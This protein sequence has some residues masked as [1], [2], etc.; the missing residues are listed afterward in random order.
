MRHQNHL[1]YVICC[2]LSQSAFSSTLHCACERNPLPLFEGALAHAV[3]RAR[4]LRVAGG[5]QGDAR[6]VG[7]LHAHPSVT[8]GMRGLAKAFDPAGAA[9]DSLVARRQASKIAN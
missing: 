3:V 6:V 2:G 5:T 7:C 8:A 1:W 4:R 9:E